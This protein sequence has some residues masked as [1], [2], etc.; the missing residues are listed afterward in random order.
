MRTRS[1]INII[2]KK[3]NSY[4]ASKCDRDFISTL[5][6][7]VFKEKLRAK[8]HPCFQFRFLLIVQRKS[9]VQSVAFWWDFTKLW[10][11]KIIRFCIQLKWRHTTEC[12][13]QVTTG[14]LHIFH[15]YG[16][17]TS[18]NKVLRCFWSFFTNLWTCKVFNG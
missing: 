2:A 18:Y 4:K 15:F 12:I 1:R 14:F 16:E 10:S 9:I 5:K 17:N 3:Q 7:F 6:K 13:K 11:Y 8:F